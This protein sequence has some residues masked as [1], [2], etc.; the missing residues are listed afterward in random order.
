MIR[1]RASIASALA[2]S[3]S[4]CSPTRKRADLGLRIE[5]D[6]RGAPAAR[7][8]SAWRAG[9]RRRA[10]ERTNSRPRK[11]LSATVICG[12]RLSSWWMIATPAVCACA[13]VAELHL[14]PAD[15][16]PAGIFGLNPGEDLHQRRLAGAVLA[17]Q[18]QHLPGGDVEVDAVQ[19]LVGAEE[20][21][22]LSRPMRRGARRGRTRRICL[23]SESKGSS[24][25]RAVRSPCAWLASARLS[26]Q[27]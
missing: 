26:R 1:M 24:S 10:A 8:M 3:T 11:T 15:F 25:I 12:T 7:G 22:D 5:A 20:L 19:H 6:R 13:D 16:E 18:R 21:G 23:A 14:S 17:H 4:C 27:S 2:I 9:G